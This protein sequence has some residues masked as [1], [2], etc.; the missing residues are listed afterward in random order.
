MAFN[1]LPYYGGFY[2]PRDDVPL[3]V[4]LYCLASG[5]STKSIRWS[6]TRWLAND[7]NGE[8]CI[9]SPVNLY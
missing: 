7:Y 9:I 4:I 3:N 2:K 1:Y 6:S 5:Y 8:V